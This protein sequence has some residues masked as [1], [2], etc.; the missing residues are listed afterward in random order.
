MPGQFQDYLLASVVE[1]RDAA[2]EIPAPAARLDPHYQ[3]EALKKIGP[4]GPKCNRRE[5]RLTPCL[6]P[7]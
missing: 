5:Q 3:V 6:T 7:N 2:L 4:A 1:L